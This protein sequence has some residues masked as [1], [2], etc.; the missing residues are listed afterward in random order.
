VRTRFLAAILFLKPSRRERRVRSPATV[1]SRSRSWC[2]ERRV[3]HPPF[4]GILYA[5]DGYSSCFVYS[6]P[7]LN[8]GGTGTVGPPAQLLVIGDTTTT[9]TNCPNTKIRI[10]AHQ[11][12]D[13]SGNDIKTNLQTKEQFASKSSNTCN[14]T[15]V[16]SETCSGTPDGI[17][18]DTLTVGCNTVDN[19]CG[20]TYAKQQWIWCNG[21]T[22]VVIGTV[23]DLVVHD[24]AISVGGS[25][26]SIKGK[27]I[28]P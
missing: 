16:T 18:H 23:G 27:V 5:F 10:L 4:T 8:P 9:G 1:P 20:Y 7:V 13:S 3:A 12:Q 2:Q 26:T 17:I 19:G 11:I 24:N 21:T 14:T 15:I 22:S 6:Q 25:F 28:K